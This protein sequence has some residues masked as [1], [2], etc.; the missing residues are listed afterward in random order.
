M[1]TLDDDARCP[2]G[3]GETYGAC[4]ARH[5]RGAP[6]PTAEALMRSRFTAFA[7]GLADYL[8]ATWHPSTRPAS[9]ELD[10]QIR[11]QRL[12]ILQT[13]GR[14]FDDAARVRFA[15]HWRTAPGI[16]AEHR[17]RG[18]QEEDSRFLREDGRWYYLDETP[19]RR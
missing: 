14:P 18:V 15:A 8:L 5:H 12:E 4:C 10:P 16:P 6:A 17:R 11:W 3:T 2:C 7:L 1:P 13:S 19:A 9:L